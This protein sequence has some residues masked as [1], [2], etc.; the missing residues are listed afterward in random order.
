[1]KTQINTSKYQYNHGKAP[2]GY[3]YWAFLDKSGDV[4]M[5]HTGTYSEAKKAAEQSNHSYLQVGS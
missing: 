4:V 5:W 2:R 1:M 3:G